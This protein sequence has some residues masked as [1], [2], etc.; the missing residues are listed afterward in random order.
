MNILP[1]KAKLK[2][3]KNKMKKKKDPNKPL[4]KNEETDQLPQKENVCFNEDSENYFQP[5]KNKI[6]EGLQEKN[7]QE[8]HG[9]TKEKDDKEV[10]KNFTISKKEMEKQLEEKWIKEEQDKR[11]SLAEQLIEKKRIETVFR[12]IN[13]EY[14]TKLMKEMQKKELICNKHER[15]L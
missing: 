11:D 7:I 2:P 3:P 4:R 9:I 1:E 12:E 14:E 6:Q 5:T 15:I 10:Q 13:R 8:E